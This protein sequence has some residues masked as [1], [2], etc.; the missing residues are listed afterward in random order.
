MRAM[1]RAIA[2]MQDWLG[3]H[4]AKQLAQA[5][6]EFYPHVAPDILVSAL[7]RYRD[8]GLWSGDVEVSREGFA[9]LACESLLS[10]DSSPH[11]AIRGLRG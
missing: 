4:S 8:A 9:R 7:A 6:A 11:A 5:S 1:I 3:Q 10:G 2:H